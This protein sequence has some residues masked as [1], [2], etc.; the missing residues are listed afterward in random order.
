MRPSPRQ[1]QEDVLHSSDSKA[2]FR[3]ELGSV[4]AELAVDLSSEP[5]NIPQN[6]TAFLVPTWDLTKCIGCRECQIDVCPYDVVTDPIRMQP[7]INMGK[8]R[9]FLRMHPVTA[10]SLI[11]VD[12]QRVTVESLH[13]KLENIS[14]ELTEDIDPR[15]V[16]VSD[17][18]WQEDG[19]I[20]YLTDDKHTTF[21][22]TP[23]FNSI[24]VLRIFL[25]Y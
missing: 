15:V 18:W 2:R 21:G 8:N 9:T 14:L 1:M 17:G 4:I 25:W 16:W 11:L 24:L 6:M 19:N 10:S 3:H 12:G 13:G 20:N 5:L 7:R 22:N 23:G